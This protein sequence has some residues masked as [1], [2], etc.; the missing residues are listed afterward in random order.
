MQKIRILSLRKFSSPFAS[1]A[2]SVA[3]LLCVGGEYPLPLCG[4]SS[5]RSGTGSKGEKNFNTIMTFLR[6]QRI[7]GYSVFFLFVAMDY[8]KHYCLTPGEA[9]GE[10]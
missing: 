8:S 9:E 6:P 7:F 10:L 1:A 3:L 2:A 4:I 5:R